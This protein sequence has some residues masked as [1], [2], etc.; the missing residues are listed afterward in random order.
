MKVNM[1]SWHFEYFK[2]GVQVILFGI[3]NQRSGGY[4]DIYRKAMYTDAVISSCEYTRAV[5]GG[6]LGTIAISTFLSIIIA[7]LSL[8]AL[9]TILVVTGVLPPALKEVFA[10]GVVVLII[11][12]SIASIFFW[13]EYEVGDYILSKFK[14]RESE[15]KPKPEPGFLSHAWDSLVSKICTKVDFE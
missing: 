13:K 11:A 10:V 9:Y 1:D 2:F 5:L 4:T 15:P 7:L 12:G 8:S 3:W 14:R 6:I